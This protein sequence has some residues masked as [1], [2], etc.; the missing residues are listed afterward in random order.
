M[1]FYSF[2]QIL[3]TLSAY[4]LLRKAHRQ[5]HHNGLIWLNELVA[6]P[7]HEGD[8]HPHEAVT[9][10]ANHKLEMD[11]AL[12]WHE[13]LRLASRLPLWRN[14][15]V[16]T[17]LVRSCAL[18]LLLQARGWQP[19]LRLGVS[20]RGGQIASHAWVELGGVM[21]GEP[22]NVASDFVVVEISAWR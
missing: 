6:A 4:C 12:R 20:K 18:T 22:A 15:R 11:Y 16:P 13:Y 10:V 3:N 8:M 21:V 2:K 14:T 1:R 9:P 7:A 5:I 17:C 19:Q